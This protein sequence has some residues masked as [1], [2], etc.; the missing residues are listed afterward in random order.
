MKKISAGTIIVNEY[1][2]ILMGRV[3]NSTPS[4]WDLP[5]GIIEPDEAPRV[6]AV[7]ECQ[8]EFGL[9]LDANSLTEIGIVQYNRE[10]NLWLFLTYVPK[11]SIDLSKLVCTTFFYDRYIKE[12]VIEVDAYSW[13][14]LN[15][16]QYE[17]CPSM[18][19]VLLSLSDKIEQE[20]RYGEY[21]YGR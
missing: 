8:E 2:E 5:K 3:T 20:S 21:R 17:C 1:N 7:R 6:A 18:I 12:D 15:S 11:A 9:F 14:P 4:I 16:I 13:V 19:R 10:K